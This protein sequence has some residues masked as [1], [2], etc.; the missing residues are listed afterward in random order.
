MA[1]VALS[2]IAI[3]SLLSAILGL[4]VT[5]ITL[6]IKVMDMVEKLKLKRKGLPTGDE[7]VVIDN[8]RY[9]RVTDE[10]DAE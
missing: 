10:D 2:P 8:K 6:V 7:E 1:G 4:I 3:I 9:K 5:I